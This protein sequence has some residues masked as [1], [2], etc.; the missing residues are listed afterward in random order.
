MQTIPVGD[1]PGHIQESVGDKLIADVGFL[2]N[3]GS[4]VAGGSRGRSGI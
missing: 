3:E 2:G 4:D 1:D